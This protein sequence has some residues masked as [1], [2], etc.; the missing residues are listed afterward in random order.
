MHSLFKKVLSISVLFMII[1][2]NFIPT[3]VLAANEVYQGA[4]TKENNVK[5]NASINGKYSAEIN[6]ENETN[7]DLFASVENGGYLKN[8]KATL[9]NN[10]YSLGE[11]T[12]EN[13]VSIIGNQIELKEV[14]LD[15][16]IEVK[17]PIKFNKQETVTEDFFSKESIVKFNA[18]YVNETG[19]EK[20]IE[21]EIKL[22][23]NWKLQSNEVISQNL[24]RYIKYENKT[25]VSFEVKEGIQENSI[26]V[27]NKNI[28]IVVPKINNQVPSKAIVT[29]QG[30]NYNYENGIV[31]I[32][33]EIKANEE[34]KYSWNSQD[35]YYVT[36]VYET[37]T[38]SKE[39]QTSAVAKVNTIK[40]DELQAEVTN[41]FSTENEV[42]SLIE[43]KVNG[44]SELNK[45]YMYTSSKSESDKIDTEYTQT[46][47]INI[48]YAD[49]LDKVELNESSSRF[50][51]T[52]GNTIKDATESVQV[53]EVSI[54]AEELTNVLGENGTIIIKNENGEEVAT[55]NKDNL[56]QNISAKSIKVETTKPQKEGNINITVK[57][58]VKGNN[59]KDEVASFK[60]L[61]TSVNAQGYIRNEEISKTTAT[62]EINFVE[63]T[64]SASLEI[65]TD[66]LSTVVENKNVVFNVVLN[67]NNIQ[68][69]LYTNPTLKL[70]L[71]QEVK[72]AKIQSAKLLY[73]EEITA[74]SINANGR[75]IE[76]KLEGN[77]TKYNTSNITNG[78][79]IVIETD[80][81]L[82]NLA[83]SNTENVVLEYT[84]EFNGESKKTE[85][86]ITIVAPTG[87]VT[88][89]TMSIDEK[90]ETAIED[91]AKLIKV[92]AT[93]NEKTMSVTA[94][95]VNNLGY[96]ANGFTLVGRIP[97]AGNKT[98]GGLDLE[99]N[100]NTILQGGIEVSGMEDA[101]VYYSV[102]GEEPVNGNGWQT[103][104]TREAKSFKIV[105]NNNFE[106]KKAASFKYLV[107]V[108]ANID[109]EKQ[110][111]ESFGIYYNNDAEDG[112]KQNLIESKVAG[113]TTGK[114]PEIKAEISAIDTN[115][116]YAINN[117]GSV[118]EGE[119]IT[120][121]VKLSNTGS[122]DAHNV[123][124]VA[125]L[126]TEI[127]VVNYQEGN[128]ESAIGYIVDK[129]TK[130]IEKEIETLNAGS[131]ETFEFQAK[132]NHIIANDEQQETPIETNFMIDADILENTLTSKYIVRNTKGTLS[133]KLSQM[134]YNENEVIYKAIISN[135]NNEEKN[136]V[137]VKFELPKGIEYKEILTGQ[138]ANYDKNTNIVT[139]NMG[140]IPGDITRTV[141]I[142]A[143]NTMTEN[144]S[145]RTKATV[146]ADGI[147]EAIESNTVELLSEVASEVIKASQ[148]TNTQNGINDQDTVE[149]YIDIENNSQKEQTLLVEDS[150]QKELKVKKYVITVDGNTVYEGATNFINNKVIIPAGK[151]A[152]VT[153]TASAYTVEQGKS[154][155][156]T[157][158]PV[159]SKINGETIN[160]NSVEINIEGTGI[161]QSNELVNRGVRENSVIEE[162][163]KTYRI[164]GTVWFDEN[165]DGKKELK[166]KK[167]A[168]IELTLYNVSSKQEV[169]KARTNENGEYSFSNLS[170]GEYTVVASY[171]STQ[172][173]V[174]NYRVDGLANS[175]N[176]DFVSAKLYDNEVAATDVI[177]LNNESEY[178]VDLGL[179]K[180]EI[181]NLEIA[182]NI[183]KVTI[184]SATNGGTEYNFREDNPVI[185][186]SSED[187][188]NATVLIEYNIKVTNN[189]DIAGYAKSIVDYLPSGM[190]FNSELNQ[191]WY[192]AKDG[193]LYTVSLANTKIEPGESKEIKLVLTKKMNGTNTGIVRGKTE[194]KTTYNE[195]GLAEINALS[196][197]KAN[198]ATSDVI[199]L[200]KSK[201]KTFATIGITIGLTAIIGLLI[202]EVK[203]YVD[204]KYSIDM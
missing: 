108:P 31:N 165:R 171:D 49:I 86:E 8:I 190:L 125:N 163:E 67:K 61:T 169:A 99:T 102:N 24:I 185:E 130:N 123:K 54:N 12:D 19:K 174:A 28:S 115:E 195:K 46:Y 176:S 100:I 189:G 119:Y 37:Q 155:K 93:D 162:K 137:T 83:P 154:V 142:K 79:L 157:N 56:T 9:E 135:V 78:S 11:T 34:G 14:D 128:A 121:R 96:D 147:N 114:A 112:V 199:L 103:E 74:G 32:S 177:K 191:D 23:V 107:T 124:A 173:E 94:N 25:L 168:G 36:Y 138:Q 110:A 29:G 170:N 55:L 179:M 39:I 88:T 160:I 21:K 44:T 164:N 80:L 175:E 47:Q 116:G 18:V 45:G 1:S 57:K 48:G 77:Q 85:K 53:N 35:I 87:F 38:N 129:N 117:N 188:E 113:I 122:T 193:N 66:R 3:A 201:V 152:R 59:S 204:R 75:E 65:S 60:K 149:F 109:Y 196:A 166:D 197:N 151:T 202:F 144:G 180:K 161:V 186:L 58:V 51:D 159:I 13:I 7:L 133:A 153:I 70:T 10:N 90:S 22:N 148:T 139:V 97:F 40:N 134:S 132:V 63:P 27:K 178:N 158:Q 64:S 17:I 106:N 15:K 68:D 20:T 30:V 156:I 50:A 62:Q 81:T 150:V 167:I 140:T 91:D 120:Y 143:N 101:V 182:K 4:E 43:V 187:V 194:I 5:L 200:K 89:N 126:P 98:I 92:S 95:L 104:F 52:E 145:L 84:N 184:V 42:G 71:P 69:A 141:S 203:K 105:K 111:K 118:T 33:K 172:Y 16:P 76:V 73:D 127:D 131:S 136:N 82:D 41:T 26:P 192:L 198:T 2:M 6:A 146:T 72:E 183:S 181:F